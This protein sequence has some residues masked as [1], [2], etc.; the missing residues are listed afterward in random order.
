LAVPDD[1]VLDCSEAGLTKQADILAANSMAPEKGMPVWIATILPEQGPTGVH[2]HFN[3]FERYLK[4]QGAPARI[5]N[6]F[7]NPMLA[8]PSRLLRRG[9]AAIA[10][11]VGVWWRTGID[12]RLL[13]S[14]LRKVLASG[15]A[16]VVYAQCP[17]S[18]HVAMRVRQN[19]QQRVVLVIHFNVS[20][21]EEWASAGQIP[22]DGALW[23]STVAR[24]RQ[25][26]AEVDGIV[27]VSRFMQAQITQRVPASAMVPSA[28][29]PN[30][31][32]IL[33]APAQGL[34]PP[35]DLVSIGTLEPRKNQAYLLDV[36]AQLHR[37]GQKLTLTLIGSGP[38]Q[39]QLVAKAKALGLEAAVY[40]AG[41]VPNASAQ[42]GQ[43]KAYVHVAHMENFPLV[44]VEAMARG[45]PLFAP[46][47]GGT[48]EAFTHGTEGWLIPLGD[49]EKA[50]QVI[51]AHMRDAQALQQASKAAKH[52]FDTCYETQML[53]AKLLDFLRTGQTGR[54]EKRPSA[55]LAMP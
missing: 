43:F 22:K 47:A 38:D 41:Y 52:R 46:D 35:T 29:I 23:R 49:A 18:A 50:A 32:Q 15:Q 39:S 14:A 10:P 7:M 11:S 33:P 42:L 30:F 5:V 36:L 24:E 8:L 12:A 55:R 53:A 20:Q 3:E 26:L 16:A 48:A 34:L 45:L 4:S 54:P 37:R 6:S 1:I 19:K 27:Y 40:F 51:G 17:I 9:L 31:V 13:G 2:T 28:L 44:L 25:V 21:A